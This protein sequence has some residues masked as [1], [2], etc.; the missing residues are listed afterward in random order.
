MSKVPLATGLAAA[1][2]AGLAALTEAAE[3]AGLAAALEPVELTG[4]GAP[5][6]ADAAPALEPAGLAA[7]VPAGPLAAGADAEGE[8]TGAAEVPQPDSSSTHK[9]SERR[10]MTTLT[11]PGRRMI[12]V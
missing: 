3:G 9:A 10:F 12:A 11:L 6:A 2:A 1:E 8:A 4:L 5:L 7:A